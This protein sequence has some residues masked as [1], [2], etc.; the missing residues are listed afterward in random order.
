MMIRTWIQ[1]TLFPTVCTSF[2]GNPHQPRLVHCQV[3]GSA[4]PRLRKPV[5]MLAR[6]PVWSKPLRLLSP[7]WRS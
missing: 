4:H 5:R 3:N 2:E 6:N 7:E 1:R